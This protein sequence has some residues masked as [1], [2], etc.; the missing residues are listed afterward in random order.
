M[1]IQNCKAYEMIKRQNIR[2]LKSDGMLLRHKK[3]G[4]KVVLL[5]NDDDNKVFYIGFRTPPTDS[6]GVAHILEHSVLCGSERFPCKDPFVELAKG[7]LNTFLNAMT[8]PDKTVYPVASCN[9]K[10][11]KNLMDVYLDAVFHPN[12]YHEEN[13]FRQE[14][15][16]YELDGPEGE[17]TLNG[18]VYNEMKGVYSSPDDVLDREIYASLFPDTP[19][20]V[21]SGGDPD[22]IPELTYRDFLDFHARY[23]HPSNAYIYLYGNAD[24]EE[25]L[26]WLDEQYLSHYD[27]ISIDSSIGTQAAF[28]KVHEIVKSYPVTEE[29]T[30][31][32]K[33][34]LAYNKV[35]A[36]S[37]DRELYVAFQVLD[38]ALCSI[39]GAPVK[40]ALTDAGIGTEIYSAYDNGIKQPY[41]SMVA[42]NTDPDKK[43]A[44]V[45]LLEETLRGLSENGIDRKAILAAI[46]YYEFKY[47]EADFGSYPKGLMYGL[48]IL[49]SWLYDE[50]L[51]FIHIEANDT[52]A[53]LRKKAENGYFEELITKYLLSNPHGS[54]ITLKPEQGLAG[55]KEKALK[56]ALAEKKAAMREDEI[57][58]VIETAAALT[59][60]QEAEDS[61]EDL[62][63]IPLLTRADLR[64]ACYPF[65]NRLACRNGT[66]VLFHDIY[67]NGIDYVTLLFDMTGVP[68]DLFPYIGLLRASLGMMDTE[69]Y[70]YGD[71][72]NEINIE[73]GGITM[74]TSVYQSVRDLGDPKLYY[75]VRVKTLH[76]KLP[77]AFSFMKEI[78]CHT[79]LH[80]R[81]R[82]REILSE[83]ISLIKAGYMSAGHSVAVLRAKS[84]YS[85]PDAYSEA[86]L[87]LRQFRFMEELDRD[88]ES[89]ADEVMDALTKLTHV[90]F[91][92][93]NL[94]VDVTADEKDDASY[95]ACIDDFKKGLFS[96]PVTEG[97]FIPEL[98]KKNEGFTFS[99]QVQ[100]VCRAG[101]FRNKGL[102][103]HGALRVLRIIMGYDYLWTNVRVKG[104]AYGCMCNFSPYGDCYFVSYRDPNLEKTIDV[105]K[106]A[107]S[108]VKN[109]DADE[110]GMTKYI[111][112][113]FSETDQPLTP[114][115]KGIRSLSAFMTDV[116]EAMLQKNRDAML[117]A[118]PETIR[119]LAPYMDAFMSDECLC[120][121]GNDARIKENG[122][123][124]GTIAPLYSN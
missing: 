80:D 2:D 64:R 15:W 36:T 8:Y 33:T 85:L 23:Y 40:R 78:L 38:Y 48:Q 27:A 94:F 76:D 71:L 30:T 63:K 46:N 6:T 77:C 43:D 1:N 59:A 39:P 52:F 13:I 119:S 5:S 67:T 24:M 51:P 117:D 104:G 58:N 32:G 97:R 22:H 49:D 79:G 26:N 37:L 50:S 53:S 25:R 116:D 16:H 34:Y 47:R 55:R 111:I 83:K 4:A 3:T 82:L 88:F 17:L 61:P 14:G 91:R 123:L 75:T 60:F 120:V 84:Y 121:V 35:I 108:F 44:F 68:A 103:Y 72:F 92:A 105:Y 106:G 69:H 56:E 19:Y 10:D 99:S 45:R 41:F 18:V 62:A 21:E 102:D 20:G 101:N 96:D 114:S 118:T 73:T 113:A 74:D 86:L 124:F 54:V 12:I 98:S 87:G 110:R 28:D 70:A 31:E 95:Y 122:S 109:F 107:S 93:E 66:D 90:I 29:E 7:S 115:G 11:F 9:D 100:Y 112:G 42:K 65:Q 57:R 81:K 89:R